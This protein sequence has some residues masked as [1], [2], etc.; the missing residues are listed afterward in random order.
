MTFWEFQQYRNTDVTRAL[1][2]LGGDVIVTDGG[3]FLDFARRINLCVQWE[4]QFSP[5]IIMRTPWLAGRIQNVQYCPMQHERES[6]PEDPYFVDGGLT[7][8]EGV[9]YQSL[10]S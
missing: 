8:T 5:R 6:F 7:E 10:W 3:Q 9:S 4:M 1:G 2:R